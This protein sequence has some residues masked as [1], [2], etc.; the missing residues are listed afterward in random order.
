[1]IY[2]VI[3]LTRDLNWSK[4]VAATVVWGR[5]F[6]SVLEEAEFLVVYLWAVGVVVEWTCFTGMSS[7]LRN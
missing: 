6:H 7:S 2:E 4:E 5:A 3:L 1:M